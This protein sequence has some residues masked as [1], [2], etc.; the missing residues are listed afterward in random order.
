MALPE[1]SE[2]FF[3]VVFL[4]D[5]NLLLRDVEEECS[6]VVHEFG[7]SHGAGLVDCFAMCKR[8]LKW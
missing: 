1:D 7:H 3:V 5:G 8:V 6:V 4:R 2:A